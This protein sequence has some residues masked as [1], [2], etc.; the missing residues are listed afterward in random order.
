MRI[1]LDVSPLL[2]TRA[3]VGTYVEQ[4]VKALLSLSSEDV[5]YLYAPRPLP[6]DD[7]AD[8]SKYPHARIIRCPVLLMGWRAWWDRVDI[9]HGMN[10]KL[11]GWGKYGSVVTIH[12]LALDRIPQRSRKLLGQRRSFLR[13]R[14]TAL[15]AA[16]VI[17]VSQHTATDIAEL[18]GVPRERIT[19]V[20]NGA[21]PDLC[22]ISDK[23]L[24]DAVKARCGIHRGGFLLSTGGGLP[25]KNLTRVIEAFALVPEL[26]ENFNLVMLGEMQRDGQALYDAVER[27]GIQAAAVFPG[28][29]PVEDLRVLYSSCY[30]FVFPSLYEGF[31]MPVLEAMACGAPVV[32]SNAA[33]LPEV[34]GDAA[35]L[36]EPT[37]TEAIASALR[38]L[39]TDPSLRQELRRRGRERAKAFSWERSARE[40][41]N[42]Y[43]GLTMQASPKKTP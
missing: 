10:Y 27:A 17:A 35:I 19:V 38:K 31:G 13:G 42:V 3:G 36:V 40:L 25:R 9:F 20:R 22:P 14:R 30:A 21:R 5:Y 11:R 26:C 16:H 7:L 15:S 24:I 37:D 39:L 43:E 41:L 34:A 33:A 32:C 12:D 23:S 18:Y 4:L 2:G 29:V 28:H 8:L 1:G 6:S